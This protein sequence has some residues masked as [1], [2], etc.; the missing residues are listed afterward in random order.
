MRKKTP[1]Y[2]YFNQLRGVLK[3]E[4][5]A[6]LIVRN[7]DANIRKLIYFT[8]LKK[9]CFMEEVVE[10]ALREYFSKDKTV[11]PFL[12]CDFV[13]DFEESFNIRKGTPTAAPK[14]VREDERVHSR[15]VVD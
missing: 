11:S 9:H 7:L 12:D 13:V 5:K 4:P 3:K 8:A 2:Q 10:T 14:K 6:G 15:S 1:N